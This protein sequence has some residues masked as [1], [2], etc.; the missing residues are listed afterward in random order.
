[1]HDPYKEVPELFNR[2]FKALSETNSWLQDT[3]DL[4]FSTE[5]YIQVNYV[6]GFEGPRVSLKY[7]DGCNLITVEVPIVF[8]ERIRELSNLKRFK[9]FDVI[10]V[11][12]SHE[13]V[14]RILSLSPWG[15]SNDPMIN[16]FD[17]SIRDSITLYR[18]SIPPSS[19]PTLRERVSELHKDL[20][21]API[22]DYYF[23]ELG[24]KTLE[25]LRR[26]VDMGFDIKDSASILFN[27]TVEKAYGVDL[28]YLKNLA[29]EK[30][31]M[32]KALDR[33]VIRDGEVIWERVK[34]LLFTPH[35]S[36]KEMEEEDETLKV[37]INR[38]LAKKEKKAE[39][40]TYMSELKGALKKRGKYS[41]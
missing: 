5:D 39:E 20:I 21:R 33:Y 2:I 40:L 12:L 11:W 13:Y 8:L 31:R 35:L 4:D 1:M 17:L 36:L 14:S 32:N 18:S 30:L 15:K 6:G 22:S 34:K 16:L 3:L 10:E 41:E 27:T 19:Y 29:D 28:E 25:A 9:L 23:T 7:M 38:I 37:L 26:V 24:Y